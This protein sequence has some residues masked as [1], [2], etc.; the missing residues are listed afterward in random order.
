MEYQVIWFVLWG[1]LW[2]VYFMTDGFDLGVGILLPVLGGDD[3]ER[4]VMLHTVGPVW[5]GNEVWLVTAG[6]ATF[7]AFPGVYALLFS[8]LYTPLLLVLFALIVRGVGFEFRGKGTTESWKQRWDTAISIS[9][10][11]IAFLFGVTFGNLFVGLPIDANGYRGGLVGLLNLYGLLTGILF[12]L[13]FAVHGA[14]WLAWKTDGKLAVRA[15]EFAGKA[16]AA[17]TVFLFLFL[18]YTASA[19]GLDRNF[20]VFPILLGFPLAALA[21]LAAIRFFLGRGR[22]LWAFLASCAAVLMT[23][24]TGIA[25][26]FPNLIPSRLDPAYSA[27]LFNASSSPYTLKIMT[28]VVMVFVP[29]VIAY[30]IWVYRVFRHKVNA[31]ELAKDEDGY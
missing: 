14:L 25:G 24:S 10:T 22:F 8:T 13:L 7:A 4:R 3:D 21:A 5:D 11:L 28:V 30:Q 31:S 23:V 2:A 26:L 6:G 19:T 17:L 9:S 15:A 18:L 20:V 29:M 16:W 27:T 12:L 1:L